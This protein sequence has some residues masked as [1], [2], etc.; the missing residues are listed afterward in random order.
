VRQRDICLCADGFTQRKRVPCRNW[1]DH[2]RFKTETT[3]LSDAW[4][5][6]DAGTYFFLV[7]EIVLISMSPISTIISLRKDE[8]LTLVFLPP[9]HS[10][11]TKVYQL[12]VLIG[13]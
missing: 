4:A 3:T 12:D 8:M 6:L 9:I 10:Q 5:T 13:H 2:S 7:S 11:S 1:G